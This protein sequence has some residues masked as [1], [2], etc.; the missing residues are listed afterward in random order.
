MDFS[1]KAELVN[2][3]QSGPF[4]L[5]F[6]SNRCFCI[7]QLCPQ[8]VR[9]PKLSCPTEKKNTIIVIFCTVNTNKDNV[10]G[11]SNSPLKNSGFNLMRNCIDFF[12]NNRTI[13]LLSD[14][15]QTTSELPDIGAKLE[16]CRLK[17]FIFFI[18]FFHLFSYRYIGAKL[19][20]CRLKM[21]IFFI[22]FFSFILIQIYT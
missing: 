19:E 8:Y 10:N 20:A 5:V 17:M 12:Q 1:K 13:I 15:R 6:N 4:R 22:F 18:F 2:T 3:K 7:R 14:T 16:A 11:S 21:F 9:Q